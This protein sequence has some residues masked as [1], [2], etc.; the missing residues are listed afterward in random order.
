MNEDPQAS[1]AATCILL[2]ICVLAALFWRAG[3]G[4]DFTDEG[5]YMIWISKPFDHPVSTQQFGYFYHVFYRLFD[6]DM[7][8]L[9]RMNVLACFGLAWW[10][11]DVFV[12][13][14]FPLGLAHRVFARVVLSGSLATAAFPMFPAGL[15]TP[16]YN[17]LAL[18]GMLLASVGLLRS[19]EKCAKAMLLGGIL[20]GIGGWMVFMGKPSSAAA[21]AIFSLAYVMIWGKRPLGFLLPAVGVAAACLVASAMCIDGS[22]G[23]FVQRL[24]AGMQMRG[25]L[26]PYLDLY[27]IFKLANPIDWAMLGKFALTFTVLQMLFLRRG[28]GWVYPVFGVA[29]C[30]LA[31]TNILSGQGVFVEESN[32]QDFSNSWAYI[33]LATALL[34]AFFFPKGFSNCHGAWGKKA[35]F[36]VILPYAYA[37][38]TSNN[39]WYQ[40]QYA[41]VFW[42]VAGLSLFALL[43]VDRERLLPS[44]LVFAICLQLIAI[45]GIS[46]LMVY[47]YRQPEPL[48]WNTQETALDE[49][50]NTLVLEKNEGLYITEAREAA[51]RVGFAGRTPIIDLSGKSPLLVY[52][53]NGEAMGAPWLIGGHVNSEA[54]VAGLLERESCEDLARAWLLLEEGSERKLSLAVLSGFVEDISSDYALAVEFSTPDSAPIKRSHALL[55]PIRNRGQAVRFCRFRRGLH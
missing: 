7:A 42:I 46:A 17:S 51:R 31:Y 39:Y 54:Y 21:L 37:F 55:K 28:L 23:G 41:K 38:G 35:V 5:F 53:L 24:E 49:S 13:N 6:G 48:L 22:I 10:F 44:L 33:L 11:L 50:G 3:Y 36:W 1:I 26:V 9:R 30:L 8:W 52:A 15:L 4:V 19:E 14:T 16:S 25:I 27:S 34:M 2:S 20:T 18:Q 12:K 45:A 40:M 43:R 47:P 29:V 32:S